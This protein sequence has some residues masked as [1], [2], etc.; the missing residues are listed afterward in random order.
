MSPVWLN[1]FFGHEDRLLRTRVRLC[2]VQL[3]GVVHAAS[4]NLPGPR[5]PSRD[6]LLHLKIV[7]FLCEALRKQNRSRVSRKVVCFTLTLRNPARLLASLAFSLC[8]SLFV[9]N[10]IYPLSDYDPSCMRRWQ[11]SVIYGGMGKKY[12]KGKS[13]SGE[14]KVKMGKNAKEGDGNSNRK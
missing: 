1:F 6:D 9:C 8:L 10:Y 5:N 3:H 7:R 11:E 4:Q 13:T 2:A 14:G 12:R